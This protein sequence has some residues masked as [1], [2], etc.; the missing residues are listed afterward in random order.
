NSFAHAEN[1]L[2]YE[3]RHLRVLREHLSRRSLVRSRIVVKN[4]RHN[5]ENGQKK[6]TQF[7][8]CQNRRF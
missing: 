1:S 6:Q 7:E 5:F 4:D 2:K 8:K 3:L